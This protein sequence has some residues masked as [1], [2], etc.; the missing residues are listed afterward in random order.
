MSVLLCCGEILA[1]GKRQN[2]QK[3]NIYGLTVNILLH[4]VFVLPAFF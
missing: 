3:D 2:A 4:P 1:V